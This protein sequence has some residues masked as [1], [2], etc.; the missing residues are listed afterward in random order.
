MEINEILVP[1]E[2]DSATFKNNTMTTGN[3]HMYNKKVIVRNIVIF[4]SHV[5]SSIIL[6]M[7]ESA[8]ISKDKKDIT[9]QV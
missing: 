4:L 1:I 9:V 2:K 7:S 5:I 6:K 8:T 3:V